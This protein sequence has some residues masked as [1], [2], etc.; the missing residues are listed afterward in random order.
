MKWLKDKMI[1]W[2]LAKLLKSLPPREI[3]VPH[4]I[5]CMGILANS[6]EDFLVTKDLIRDLWGYKVRVI[7]LF[8]TEEESRMVEAV[9]HKNFNWLALPSEYFNEFLLEKMDFI[10][11]PSLQLNPYL[12]YLL[13]Q[14]QSGFTIGLYSDEN[15]P[16]L[17]L[18]LT[19]E[20][21]DL[22]SNVY[23]LIEYLKKIKEA[24]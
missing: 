7:G 10:L 22:K 21:D 23:H 6:E 3:Q 16:Y 9:S 14:N 2:Q 4:Q 19:S 1:D 12:R 20:S 5:R 24:C 11:I 18:M 17:D 15:K 13:L 8:Y